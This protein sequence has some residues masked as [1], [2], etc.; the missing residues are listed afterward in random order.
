MF[1]PWQ[2]DT[3]CQQ[4]RCEVKGAT[5][6]RIRPPPSLGGALVCRP[7]GRLCPAVPGASST[8]GEGSDTVSYTLSSLHCYPA[9]PHRAFSL[10]LSLNA[11]GPPLLLLLRVKLET[12]TD[13]HRQHRRE[14]CLTAR[15]LH[16]PPTQASLI[17]S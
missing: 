4:L 14:C 11:G 7:G 12:A 2:D 1:F 5:R 8:K 16:Y 17:I 13:G 6:S 3:G 9:P 15:L 10:K